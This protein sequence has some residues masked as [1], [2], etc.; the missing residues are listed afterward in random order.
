[1]SAAEKCLCTG[2]TKV[3]VKRYVAIHLGQLSLLSPWGR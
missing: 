2:T 1:V 3:A